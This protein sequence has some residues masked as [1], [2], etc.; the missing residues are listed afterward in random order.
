MDMEQGKFA[1]RK[2]LEAAR[3]ALL[4]RTGTKYQAPDAKEQLQGQQQGLMRPRSRPPVDESG[5]LADG[6]GLALME[7][8][9][10]RKEEQSEEGLKSSLRPQEPSRSN[11]DIMDRNSSLGSFAAKLKQSESGGRDDV[12]ITIDDGRTMTGGYQFGDARLADYKKA[13]KD[14]FSTEEFRNDASLQSKV[15]EWHIN[16]IDKT[17]AKLPGSDKMS[18]DGLRAVAH[19]GGKSGMK[20]Y[21]TT[22]GKYNPADKFG[23]RLSDYYNKFK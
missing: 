3:K 17:I 2:N 11:S 20:K 1:Y 19:L 5:S 21:V 16:D 13:N 9:Q 8:M 23:T 6:L 14:N 22:G 4:D 7:N 18:T 10:A 12:Q 15:F